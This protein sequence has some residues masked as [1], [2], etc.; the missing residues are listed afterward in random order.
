MGI[1][2]H[3]F[4]SCSS[5]ATT[6]DVAPGMVGRNRFSMLHDDRRA[7]PSASRR[8]GYALMAAWVC[9]ILLGSPAL[10]AQPGLTG[11]PTGGAESSR[12]E[13]K[14]ADEKVDVFLDG[15]LFTR[16]QTK[17]GTKP[18]LWPVVG[19]D[20]VE[21]TR[22]YPMREATADEKSDH[23]HHRSLW[24]THGDV[25]G[26]DYWKEPDDG[27]PARGFG[28][29]VHREFLV[30]ESHPVAQIRTRNEWI[31]F[32]GEKVLSDYRTIGFGAD[33]SRRWID[34]DIQLVA[35]T[36]PVK[37]GDT[38]EGCFGVRVAGWMRADDQGGMIVNNLKQQGEK[39][40]WGKAASWVDY[41]GEKN[42]EVYGIA[43]MNHPSS[44]RF[45]TFWHVRAYGLFA[46]N[47]FGLHNFKNSD[48]EDGSLEL[49]PGESITFSYRVLLHKGDDQQGRVPEAFIDY[50]KVE[51]AGL[52]SEELEKTIEQVE[53]ARS[54]GDDG[55]DGSN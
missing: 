48:E 39:N 52:L 8:A 12:F 43:I 13:L 46:A 30:V 17:S 33:A 40:T 54:E 45:P 14:R 32:Q 29:I 27:E 53:Q 4:D 9:S 35:D 42:G 18:I 2:I 47:V 49:K 41:Y 1:F 19:P 25:N 5:G 11:I 21:L 10:M 50:A 26:V 7:R 23:P 55:S 44:C 22:G 51:K 24:F 3:Q 15:K 38:K 37:F 20:E 36:E 34:F 16:Y 28:Q 6:S 31:D